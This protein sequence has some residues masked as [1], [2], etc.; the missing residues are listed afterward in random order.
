[1]LVYDQLFDSDGNVLDNVIIG[2]AV[3]ASSTALANT[4]TEPASYV[5]ASGVGTAYGFPDTF[6]GKCLLVVSGSTQP[7]A[8]TQVLFCNSKVWYRA[9]VT[10]NWKDEGNFTTEQLDEVA[11]LRQKVLGV[12]SL[13]TGVVLL[14]TICMFS[15]T[16]GGDNNRYPIPLGTSEPNTNWCICDG[17]TT[18][19]LVVPDLRN[20]FIVGSGSDYITG[21]TGGATSQSVTVS[22]SVGST[23]LSVS[24]MPSHTHSITSTKVYAYASSNLPGIDGQTNNYSSGA[25]GGSSSHS[26]TF[27]GGS[28]TVTTLPPYY[29]LAFII[30]IKASA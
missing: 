16:F 12:E 28:Q 27:S 26:H 18:N 30:M 25:T 14:G 15:G 19:G 8:T 29:A 4:F 23:T 17:V 24:Q 9:S 3:S 2:T 10:D 20:R 5:F 11:Q 13:L 6:T 22:G 1:M 7:L 21:N